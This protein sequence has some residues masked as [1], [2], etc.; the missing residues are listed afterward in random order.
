M[1]ALFLLALLYTLRRSFQVTTAMTILTFIP[2]VCCLGAQANL[3]W[4]VLFAKI[5]LELI[6]YFCVTYYFRI[7]PRPLS[8]GRVGR[9]KV[10]RLIV[11]QPFGFATSALVFYFI[12]YTESALLY[13]CILSFVFLIT[14]F[15]CQQ[16]YYKVLL[17]LDSPH[18]C[19]LLLLL[20]KEY[21][22]LS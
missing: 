11:A 12:P 17:S 20:P 1:K 5:I 4:I 6:G 21:P 22:H 2:L 8:H 15:D 7:V 16:E 19:H 3:L 14:L 13:G 9:L 18:L 10:R